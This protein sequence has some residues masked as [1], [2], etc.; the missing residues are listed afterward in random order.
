MSHG[1]FGAGTD[2]IIDERVRSILGF[3][4]GGLL[5]F[6]ETK[7]SAIDSGVWLSIENMFDLEAVLDKQSLSCIFASFFD[8]KTL[9]GPKVMEPALS[10][11]IFSKW[12]GV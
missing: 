2:S 12:L 4:M 7:T 5:D 6:G 9:L 3:R 8:E 11:L 1:R 10:L